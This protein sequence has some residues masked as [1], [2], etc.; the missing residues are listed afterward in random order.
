MKPIYR[1]M[2]LGIGG[3]VAFSLV[4]RGSANWCDVAGGV[5][6]GLVWY[7]LSRLKPELFK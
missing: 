3:S 1:M 4:A 6:G 5:I 2:L 7:G